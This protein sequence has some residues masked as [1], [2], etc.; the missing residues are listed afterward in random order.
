MLT[1]NLLLEYYSTTKNVLIRIFRTGA[2]TRGVKS[3]WCEE[4]VV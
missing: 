4:S 1:E 3:Q 2:R